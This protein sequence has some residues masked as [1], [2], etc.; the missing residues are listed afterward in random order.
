MASIQ[1]GIRRIRVLPF[2]SAVIASLPCLAGLFVLAHIVWRIPVL[3]FQAL[4]Y[5]V[6]L[7]LAMVYQL[8]RIH[9]VY[10]P[11]RQ[12]ALAAKDDIVA[13]ALRELIRTFRWGGLM[14]LLL[15]FGVQ[16]GSLFFR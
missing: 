8:H 7:I 6:V 9:R 10:A 11:A 1:F 15:S 5:F 13:N 14:V 4:V 2:S 16:W 3:R 12:I